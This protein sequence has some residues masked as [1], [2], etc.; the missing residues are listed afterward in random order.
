MRNRV[1]EAQQR[2]KRRR[3]QQYELMAAAGTWN[4]LFM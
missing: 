3:D 1:E 2:L 4:D